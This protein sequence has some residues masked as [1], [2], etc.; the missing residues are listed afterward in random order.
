MA[1]SIVLNGEW[2]CFSIPDGA[3]HLFP[4][5]SW[6]DRQTIRVRT[7][8]ALVD[9]VKNNKSELYIEKIPKDIFDATMMFHTPNCSVSSTRFFR[10]KDYDGCESLELHEETFEYF[11]YQCATEKKA[12]KVKGILSSKELTDGEKLNAIAE[13]FYTDDSSGDDSSSSDDESST[14][15][16]CTMP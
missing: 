3:K 6:E 7:N 9:Y 15:W 10:V 1:V 11:K 8:P 13:I 4:D 12:D 14:E 16:V 2:G 5:I